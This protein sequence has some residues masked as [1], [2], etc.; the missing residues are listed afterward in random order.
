MM[1]RKKGKKTLRKQPVQAVSEPERGKPSGKRLSL[2]LSLCF[3]LGIVAVLSI[4]WLNVRSATQSRSGSA[5]EQHEMVD[6]ITRVPIRTHLSPD[7]IDDAALDGWDTEVFSSQAAEQL[8]VLA[9]GIEAPSEAT[10]ERVLAD[11]VSCTAFIGD[12]LETVFKDD[13]FH[14]QRAG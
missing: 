12:P 3:A 8:K 13:V 10:W 11:E 4:V 2:L 9:R 14:I 7:E 1:A 5:R 6:S